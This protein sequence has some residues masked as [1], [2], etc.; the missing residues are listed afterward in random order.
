MDK[1]TTSNKENLIS[2]SDFIHDYSNAVTDDEKSQCLQQIIK[3]EY[4]PFLVK[5]FW[6]KQIIK[7]ANFDSEGN[8]HF[9]SAK[10][11]LSYVYTVLNLYT[12]LDVSS[13]GFNDEFDK[14]EKNHLI[15]K[16]EAA[17]PDDFEEFQFVYE[18]VDEDFRDNYFKIRIN[19]EDIAVQV[20]TGVLKGANKVMDIISQV[21]Q[22]ENVMNEIQK[23]VSQISEN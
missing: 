9:D 8:V 22:D 11:Y 15:E 18:M 14:L 16:I 17:L 1:N 12:F 23:A 2:V 10:Q 5:L 19:A 21:M 6:A 13:A 7:G 3:N 20:E 4:V